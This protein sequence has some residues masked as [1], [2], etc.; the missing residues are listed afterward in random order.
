MKHRIGD[1][2]IYKGY[3][4]NSELVIG[5]EYVV[6]SLHRYLTGGDDYLLG[7]VGILMPVSPTSF[8]LVTE[9]RWENPYGD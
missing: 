7:L 8:T 5:Q 2:V 9:G 4:S 6:E 3:S 1:K